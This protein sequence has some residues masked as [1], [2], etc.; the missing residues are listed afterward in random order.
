VALTVSDFEQKPR[1]ASGEIANRAAL[2]PQNSNAQCTTIVVYFV[3]K[4]D[5]AVMEPAAKRA[6]KE[7]ESVRLRHIVVRHQD[8]SSPFDPVRNVQVQRTAQE[9]EGI[10]RQALQELITEAKTIKLPAGK[11]AAKS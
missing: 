9:A 11:K 4:D 3:P 1:A 8:C 6:K 7:A 5:R 2:A 10:L